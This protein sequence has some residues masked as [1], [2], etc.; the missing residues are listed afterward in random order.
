MLEE[1]CKMGT[2]RR[3]ILSNPLLLIGTV[4]VTFQETAAAEQCATIMNGRWF[5]GR[6][7]STRLYLPQQT[8]ASKYFSAIPLS[9]DAHEIDPSI[10]ISS[11]ASDA[12]GVD[13]F[14]NS[15]L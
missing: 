4:A 3:I 14:L 2:V 12:D 9:T 15:L 7:L 8:P 6:L 10:S 5:D 11:T 13:D 1:F